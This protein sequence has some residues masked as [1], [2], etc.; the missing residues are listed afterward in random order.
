MSF[1]LK[2]A[3]TPVSVDAMKGYLTRAISEV[4]SFH[5]CEALARALGYRTYA[6]LLH[7][8]S[9]GSDVPATAEAMPFTTYLAA[10]GFQIAPDHLFRAVASGALRLVHDHEPRLTA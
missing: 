10:H 4:K 5:R 8:A 3:V 1:A 9:H 6:T 2:I 7:A